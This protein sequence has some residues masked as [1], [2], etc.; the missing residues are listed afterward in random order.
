VNSSELAAWVQAIGSIA[1]VVGAAWIAGRQSRE[2]EQRARS[3]VEGLKKSAAILISYAAQRIDLI[4]KSADVQLKAN[5]KMPSTL[6][7]RLRLV[8]DQMDRFPLH[9]LADERA[10]HVFIVTR[11]RIAMIEQR[12]TEISGAKA[13]GAAGATYFKSDIS[14][15]RAQSTQ[16]AAY[17][18]EMKGRFGLAELEDD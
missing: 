4:A 9:R 12:C 18:D 1:A 11:N 15:L 7:D 3:E 6:V 16:A 8:G 5:K 17:R 13:P 10:M 14:F 2:A